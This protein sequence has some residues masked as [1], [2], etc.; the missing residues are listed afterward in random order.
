M[1][2][3]FILLFVELAKAY[4]AEHPEEVENAHTSN[5]A[6]AEAETISEG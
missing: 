2:K 6:N 4:Y 3:E 5:A 1:N